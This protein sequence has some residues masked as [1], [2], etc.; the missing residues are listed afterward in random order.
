VAIASQ[1][2][3]GQVADALADALR[4]AGTPADPLRA[5]V[6]TAQPEVPRDTVGVLKDKAGTLTFYPAD[7]RVLPFELDAATAGHLP[8]DVP[9]ALTLTKRTLDSVDGNGTAI[10]APLYKIGGRSPEPAVRAESLGQTGKQLVHIGDYETALTYLKQSLAIQQEIGDSAG[11]CATLFNMGHIHWQNG[12]QAEALAAW[13]MVYRLAHSMHLAQAL[14]AL[15]GLAGQLGLPGGMDG[16]EA[17]ARQM[18][19]SG[20]GGPESS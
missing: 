9:L 12:E 19:G 15:V 8:L 14:D 3:A 7:E 1:D 13:V 6:A 11:L 2:D 16:W 17:L 4:T 5:R 20:G 18:D 10:S